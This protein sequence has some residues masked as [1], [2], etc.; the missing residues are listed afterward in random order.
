MQRPQE[1]PG[2][3]RV[4]PRWGRALGALITI[5]ILIAITRGA[6]EI[7]VGTAVVALLVGG[8]LLQTRAR[9]HTVYDRHGN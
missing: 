2:T 4:Q 6:W 5:V 8:Y 1:T 7:A 9:R 3:G